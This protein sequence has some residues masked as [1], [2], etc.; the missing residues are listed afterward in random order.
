MAHFAKLN[1]HNIVEQV[2]V[3]HN[4]EL[5]ING[6]ENE[7]KGIEFCQSLLGG[8]WVQT[9]Y[10]ATFR[11]KFAGIGDKYDTTNDCFVALTNQD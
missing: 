10:N 4:N 9:S 7:Q 5:L 6:V 11:G 2:I 8:T 3:V 1:A